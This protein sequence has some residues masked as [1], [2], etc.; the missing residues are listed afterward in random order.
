MSSESAAHHDEDLK[1]LHSMG[2]AQELAR[3]MKGFQ[4][5]AIS[6]SIICILSGGINSLGQGIG[7]VGGA[8]IGIGWILGCGVSFIFALGMAQIGSAYPTAGGLYHWSSTLG[9]R[10]YGWLTAWL[11]LIGLVTVLGAI[12][13]GTYNF[14]I[15]A[16]GPALGLTTSFGLQAAFVIGI[17]V[18]QSIVNH[19]GIRA[20]ARLTDLSG[21]LIFAVA[22]GLTVALLAYAPSW[23]F[24]R[25]WTFKNYSGPAGGD[26]WPA[27]ESMLFLFGLGLLLPIYTITGF[28]A[29]AHTAEET[30]DASR[31]VPKGIINS[32]VWSALFGWV[33]LSAFVLAIP[34]M[35]KAAASGWGVFFFTLDA[36][37]P[38]A[39]KQVLYVLIFVCQ[40]ICGLATV[41]S[42]SRMIFAFARDGGLPASNA[43]KRVHPGFRTPVAAIWT[44]ALISIAFTL[45]TP[46]YATI[47]SVTVIFIFISYGLPVIA[48]LFAYGNTWTKM[49]PWDMGPAYRVV[50]VLAIAA[51]ALIFYLGV[52]PPNGA[53]LTIT[54]VFLAITAVV[55]FG[56]ERRRFKGPPIGDEVA[57]RQAEIAAAESALVASK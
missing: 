50:G 44:A 8:A 23:E 11:N 7:G 36:V 56:F 34:D 24:S 37:L 22:V 27:T 38:G 17:T 4:N 31:A 10:G 20:T 26:V 43:L 6:F 48:G 46:A 3:N 47:V 28:D 18:I 9:G 15:G 29:S 52:Q 14:F 32:V 51:I 5:F 33:M 12:N 2:Y 16:F 53:A 57:K 19:V 42:A 49:G 41:T 54:L 13:V 21:Y 55:W 35:D 1:V 45:Y 25:L 39:L 40:F 30:K